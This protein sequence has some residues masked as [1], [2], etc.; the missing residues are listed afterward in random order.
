MNGTYKLAIP[1][2][3]FYS[4]LNPLAVIV[5]FLYFN[6][7]DRFWDRKYMR[8]G[9]NNSKKFSL[10]FYEKD[11]RKQTRIF[12]DYARDLGFKTT[13]YNSVPQILIKNENGVRTHNIVH[14]YDVDEIFASG[15][16]IKDSEKPDKTRNVLKTL[17]VYAQ[18][19][20]FDKRKSH[21]SPDAELNSLKQKLEAARTN[22]QEILQIASE[23]LDKDFHDKPSG[24]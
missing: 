11:L 10:Y 4:E 13:S 6:V 18:R 15:K 24:D 8:K 16:A 21:E 20:T 23:I 3:K 9:K 5:R 7:K 2:S 17:V 12:L 14:S 22:H 1:L 19:T